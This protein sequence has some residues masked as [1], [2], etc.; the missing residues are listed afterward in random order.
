MRK[1][2][3]AELHK[4]ESLGGIKDFTGLFENDGRLTEPHKAYLREVA[5]QCKDKLTQPPVQQQQQAIDP[6]KSQSARD[7]IEKM[8]QDATDLFTLETQVSNTINGYK[9]KMTSADH[10]AVINLYAQRKTLLSQQN[11]F[12]PNQD[13]QLPFVDSVI[14]KIRQAQTSDELVAIIMDPDV[15]REND[16]RINEAYDQRLAELQG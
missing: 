13:G 4:A 5:Q 11:M 16:K 14:L 12:E 6:I 8:I 3:S 10:Q 2:Y 1:L 7:G 15:T 9:S